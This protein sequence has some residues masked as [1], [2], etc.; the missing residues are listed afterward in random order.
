MDYEKLK[1]LS[2]EE[3]DKLYYV[4]SYVD[5]CEI[6]FFCSDELKLKEVSNIY[7]SYDHDIFKFIMSFNDSNKG[8]IAYYNYLKNNNINIYSLIN[9]FSYCDVSY[10]IN[11][12]NLICEYMEQNSDFDFNLYN[13]S[14]F[15]KL[16]DDN[17][18]EQLLDRL[19]SI[20][21]DRAIDKK[22]SGTSLKNVVAVFPKEKRLD[23]FNK[24]IDLHKKEKLDSIEYSLDDILKD[25]DDASRF[26][27][28]R[29]YLDND[30]L[31]GPYIISQIFEV[32]S[33]EVK[34]EVLRFIQE[35]ELKNDKKIITNVVMSACLGKYSSNIRLEKFR[36]LVMY[37]DNYSHFVVINNLRDVNF[38]FEALNLKVSNI[39]PFLK[40][41]GKQKIF[42]ILNIIVNSHFDR[43][44]D[45]FPD[46][47][48]VYN[49]LIDFYVDYLGLNKDNLIKF[50]ERFGYISLRYL[51]SNNIRSVINLES[52]KFNSLMNLF[53]ENNLNLDN[54]TYNTVINAILQR[55]FMVQCKD[56]YNIFSRFEK[57]INNSSIDEVEEL[58]LEMSSVVNIKKVLGKYNID[59]NLF[60]NDLINGDDGMLDILH[61]ITNQYIMKKREMYVKERMKSVNDELDLNKRYEKNF[62]KKKWIAT[63]SEFDISWDIRAIDDDN[64]TEEQSFLKNNR[65]ILDSV[66]K[67]KKNPKEYVLKDEYKKFIKVFDSLVDILYENNKLKDPTNDPNA[68]YVYSAKNI[69]LYTFIDLISELDINKIDKFLL[70]D[71]NLLKSLDEILSKYKLLGWGST[72]NALSDSADFEFSN[73]TLVGLFDYFYRINSELMNT[74]DKKFSLSKMVSLSNCYAS[75]SSK[76]GLLFGKD[77]FKLIAA[78]E[79]K[80]KASMVKYKRLQLGSDH[81]FGM[82]NRESVPVPPMDSNISLD[83]GKMVNVV[84]GNTTNMQ[85]LALGEL[86]NACMRIG[87]AFYDFYKECLEGE[88]GFHIVLS[89]PNTDKFI[90]RVS[91]IRNGNTLFLNELRNSECAGY[92]N[93]DCVSAIRMV[94]KMLVERSK[95]SEF[96][97][98]NV[99]ITSD[100]AMEIHKDELI[101]LHLSDRKEA[102]FGLNHNLNTN[103]EG[104]LL[105]SSREDGK[106]VV[107][108]LGRDKISYYRPQRGCVKRYYGEDAVRRCVQMKMIQELLIGISLEDIN[109]DMDLYKD[110]DMCIG[111]DDWLAIKYNNGYVEAYALFSSGNWKVANEEMLNYVVYS[112]DDMMYRLV[113]DVVSKDDLKEGKT[114]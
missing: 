112:N 13:I 104:I 114:R 99:V 72:F 63:T 100:Y 2:K 27:F 12:A 66:I 79:G 67:F 91:G 22:I 50:I 82:Y 19:L 39:F 110:V 57:L 65:E 86:T 33:D 59:L 58:I 108:N 89:E 101:D 48:I 97:I 37:N 9:K 44:G 23:I 77:V 92:D 111:G 68:K 75:S 28:L 85:N 98:D 15:L 38:K 41:E 31:K 95:G 103:G 30:L 32:F 96:P 21:E 106:L 87:G 84:V 53:R 10:R 88:V 51:D 93:E 24:F 29:V 20:L 3:V 46:S 11:F 1:F 18:K 6:I 109:I 70:G 62:I 47:N 107:I 71:E 61:E 105:A 81:V 14:D 90:S 49:E 102:L 76:Y 69:D 36:N 43:Y 35:Y 42:N 60:L 8:K 64:L 94:A 74:G 17:Y 78:N 16:Y 7:H 45:K 52:N 5:K 83:N 40:E 113:D 56:D 54:D 73:N 34:D 80:N 26:D 55:E 4:S 25:M